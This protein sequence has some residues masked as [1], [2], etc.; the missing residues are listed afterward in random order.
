MKNIKNEIATKGHITLEYP[1]NLRKAVEETNALWEKFCELP[2]EVKSSLV[3]SNNSD[4]VGYELKNGIGK[5][6]DRKENFDIAIAGE[7]WLIEN[8]GKIHDPIALD[9]LKSAVSLVDIMKSTVFDF[10]LY[11]EQE[12]GI[13]GFHNEVKDSKDSF[14]VRFIHYFGNRKDGE[15]TATAHTDQSGFTFHL[16][17]SEPGL[18]SLNFGGVWEDMPVSSGETVIIPSMQL[19]LRT[20]GKL[21]ALCHRVVATHTTAKAGRYSAVCFVQLKNTSKYDKDKHGRLQEK[22]P[23]FNYQMSHEEFQ[24]LFK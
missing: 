17:E 9:F 15:E 22:T 12:Y 5:N 23:G 2:E 21:K 11:L 20:K 3:Y 14:F 4:G 1:S 7:K 19:Q 6:A 13:Q 18:Q 8:L 16:Y 24:K 10:A